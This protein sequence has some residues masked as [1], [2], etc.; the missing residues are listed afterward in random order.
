MGSVTGVS[1]VKDKA[2][3]IGC[4]QYEGHTGCP[5]EKRSPLLI[6]CEMVPPSQ[7]D[8]TDLHRTGGWVYAMDKGNGDESQYCYKSL[9]LSNERCHKMNAVLNVA[10]TIHA[11]LKICHKQWTPVL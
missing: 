4:T 10:R 6:T 7:A 2:A 11:L 5:S 8:V 9:Y 1:R 3:D